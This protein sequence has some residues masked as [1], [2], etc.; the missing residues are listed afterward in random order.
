LTTGGTF[1]LPV[2]LT[3]PAPS[4]V[5]VPFTIGG[6]AQNG[7]NFSSITAS[8]LVIPAGS[9]GADITGNLLGI[10]VSPLPSTLIITLGAPTT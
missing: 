6:T 9:T 7:I 10:G 3:A 4:D 1:T 8:P 2:N 5:S